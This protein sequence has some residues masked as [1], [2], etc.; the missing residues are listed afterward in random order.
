MSRSTSAARRRLRPAAI[1][2]LAF[3]STTALAACSLSAADNSAGSGD[4]D[5]AAG[6]TDASDASGETSTDGAAAGD[7]SGAITLVTHDSFT[8]SEGVLEAFTDETGIEV[9][10]VAPGDGG[11]LVN[12]LVLT[13]DSP[14]GD[15]VY[16]V[17]NTFASRAIEEGVFAPYVSPALPAGIDEYLIG[18]ELTPVDLSDV[19]LNVDTAWYEAAGQTP[20]TSLA[21][22]TKPEYAGQ[23]VLTSPATSSPGLAFLLATISAFGEDGWQDYWSQLVANDVQITEGWSDAYY[24][25]FTGGGGEGTRPIVLSYASSP[26]YTVSEAT[27]EPTTAALLDT[28]F[29]QVEYAGVIEGAENPRGAQAFVDF[30]LSDTFQQDLPTAMYVYPINPSTSLP[31]EWSQWA[32]MAPEPLT[33]PAEQ[34]AA[35]RAD[36]ID[37]WAGIAQE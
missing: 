17:D 37:Q 20:P 35:S 22:L 3:L 28:C 24:V 9:T 25:D 18:D 11:A 30:L 34:I 6:A 31:Q 4:G 26:P 1:A 15:V 23:T 27:G 19:C 2:A 12:Q 16:G 13:K 8:P 33:V 5:D 14:L 36:W 29:R 10:V 32:P 7:A 21:D